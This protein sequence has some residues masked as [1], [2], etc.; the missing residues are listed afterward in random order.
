MVGLEGALKVP[1]GFEPA[2]IQTSEI[3]S[4]SDPGRN[5]YAIGAGTTNTGAMSDHLYF[6]QGHSLC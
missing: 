1:D 6:A 5:V 4:A 2:N 3:A